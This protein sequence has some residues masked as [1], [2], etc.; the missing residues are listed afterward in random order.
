MVAVRGR[1]GLGSRR[2]RAPDRHERHAVR[3]VERSIRDGCATRAKYGLADRRSHA[4]RHEHER[5]QRCTHREAS[6]HRPAACCFLWLRRL[7]HRLERRLRRLRH[8]EIDTGEM[9]RGQRAARD[10]RLSAVGRCGCVCEEAQV[11]SGSKTSGPHAF[12]Y[13]TYLRL[14]SSSRSPWPHVACD[15]GRMWSVE[16]KQFHPDR[17]RLHATPR[18]SSLALGAFVLSLSRS[19]DPSRRLRPG[20]G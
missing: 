12:C 7:E 15:G 19:A 5:I 16:L 8:R 20:L 17:W 3:P 6:K 2:R 11:S 10:V 14:I 13:L 1:A 4:V 9:S 18:R